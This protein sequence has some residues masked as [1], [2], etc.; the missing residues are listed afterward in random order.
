MAEMGQLEQ[1]PP[2]T[3]EFAV[4]SLECGVSQPG[5]I[6]I[7]IYKDIVYIYTYIMYVCK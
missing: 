4:R 2:S 6:Y 1:V 3:Y 7:Y 5:N